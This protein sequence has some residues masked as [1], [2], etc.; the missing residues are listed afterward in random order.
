MWRKF[1]KMMEKKY[2]RR[3]VE[4]EIE[5]WNDISKLNPRF[6][7]GF[8]FRGMGDYNWHLESSLER[9]IKRFHSK[10]KTA[11]RIYPQGYEMDMLKE[12]QWKYPKYEK[13]NNPKADDII[14]WLSI[15]Q[16][17]GSPTRLVDFTYSP[18]VALFMAID[19]SNEEN[20]ASLWCLNEIIL[21]T[22]ICDDYEKKNDTR[23]SG[24]VSQKEL[25]YQ[26][27][28][29]VLYD[30]IMDDGRACVPNIYLVQPHKVNERILAQQG[31]FAIPEKIGV[32]FEENL[33]SL[34]DNQNP[35]IV[36][37]QDVI[38][39]SN[40]DK[41]FKPHDYFL[42]K[43]RIPLKFRLDITKSLCL[44]NISAETMY[45]GLEG[46]AKSLNRQRYTG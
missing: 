25:I 14:E 3:F 12:F 34:V 35:E 41:M 36:P 13:I 21:R 19:S 1:F 30:S 10:N 23:I 33:F 6:L 15:M 20:D 17:Y 42:I 45:P 31:L 11:H 22:I 18:Y 26:I 43:I 5:N 24:I 40:S 32:P 39:Y 29:K 44:M 27:A 8:V 9:M 4:T 7:S 37:F 16:H 46:L 38:E 28:N 2:K